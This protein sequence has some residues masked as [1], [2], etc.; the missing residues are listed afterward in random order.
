[1]FSVLDNAPVALQVVV[2]LLTFAITIPAATYFVSTL[3]FQSSLRHF[4]K[5]SGRKGGKPHL[6]PL[7]P[8]KIPVLGHAMV[9]LNTKPGR[10]HRRMLSEFYT[11]P[12]V[13]CI[14]ILLAGQRA[15]IISSADLVIKLFKIRGVSRHKFNRDI[16]VNSNG[17]VG[18]DIVRAYER[19]AIDGRDQNVINEE[20][21][22][23]YLLPQHAVN[24]LTSKFMDTF[25]DQLIQEHI[26][27]GKEVPLYL[28][29]RDRMFKASTV[30]LYGPS[31]LQKIPNLADLFWPFDSGTLT[32][33]F[34]VPKA[35]MPG[36]YKA[37]D[38][39]LDPWEQWT[40]Y[41][42]A[43]GGDK[44]M[45]VDWDELMG[46]RIVRERHQMYGFL[47]LSDRARASFDLGFMFGL[48]S[49]AIPASGW[50]LLHLLHPSNSELLKIVQKEVDRAR[51]SDGTID[52]PTLMSSTY[53]NSCF[54]ETLRVYVDVL[55]T[56]T[57][58]EDLVLDQYRMRKGD[59]IIA[60][61]YVGGHDRW[62]S[63]G[64]VPPEDVWFG[65][66][67]LKHDEK[68]GEVTF[69]TN[70]ING[71]YF[72][73]GGGTYICP[74][75]VF[76]KQEVFGAVATFLSVYE[77]QAGE[78]VGVTRR[79][80]ITKNKTNSDFP[81]VQEGF[82]GAGVVVPGGDIMVKLKKRKY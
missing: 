1:M 23:K 27:G 28:F 46:A 54:H 11:N 10:F 66:R 75:R 36:D 72:P 14:S 59:L 73:F 30:A 42:L 77:A 35:L 68:T 57:L 15:H 60:P 44:P 81:G 71:H 47:E 19:T 2:A 39:I 37:L 7:L 61:S 31:I 52:V 70:G 6:P 80:K 5:L 79:G 16:M 50:M 51:R 21:N 53:M 24:V 17:L 67:F 20:I 25:Y 55:V 62:W 32:R 45:E 76:A 13:G 3:G 58:T 33:L 48:N 8:Y 40:K 22:N 56:R 78:C 65:E 63:Q 43:H 34:Q 82:S 38:D 9:F 4:K 49:N 64:N 69:S 26:D 74:G 29:L 12:Q 18:E 41:A